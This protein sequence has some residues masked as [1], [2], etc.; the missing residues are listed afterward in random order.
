[1]RKYSEVLK[2][3]YKEI[4]IYQTQGK[5]ALKFD[6]SKMKAFAKKLDNPQKRIK[7]IHIGGTNG[8]GSTVHI[9]AAMLQVN[10]KRVGIFTS[11][12]LKDFR[13]RIKINGIYIEKDYVV[14]FVNEHF[15]FV[16]ERSLSF[17]ELTF[18]LALQYFVDRKIDIAIIEVGMGGRLDATNIIK[19]EISVITNIGF[20]HQEFL[21]NSLKK[22]AKEKAGII[23]SG[24]PVIIGECNKEIDDVF[25][26][27]A[28]DKK[29]KIIFIDKNLNK[30]FDTD[31]A[32]NYQRLNI[33]LAE[34]VITHLKFFKVSDKEKKLALKNVKQLTN[35]IGRWDI[36]E[37]NPR[38]VVDIAHNLEGFVSLRDQLL[39]EKYEKLHIVIGFVKNK[40][41]NQL[42]PILPSSAKFYFC[43][44]NIDRGMNLDK[45]CD[46]GSKMSIS[47]KSFNSVKLALNKAKENATSKDLVLVTGSTFVVAEIL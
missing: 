19:P 40:M 45:L 43:S 26:K 11:P 29:T 2:F 9:I 20:D 38:V 27:K 30:K 44:P 23:K 34:H 37:I 6:L 16:I 46:I 3:L 32:P 35:F 13:E 10:K 7:S 36:L 24:A 17:F 42:L 8:K 22:I 4:P 28:N 5:E 15:N 25:R 31:L 41:V 1:M 18:G 14:D 12:H 21:G 39:N 33:N 47:F